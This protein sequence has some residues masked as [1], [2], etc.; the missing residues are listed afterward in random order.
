MADRHDMKSV[1]VRIRSISQPYGEGTGIK[2]SGDDLDG[3][4][5]LHETAL[6]RLVTWIVLTMDNSEGK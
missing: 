5:P 4:D 2:F 1:V 3:N 6:D